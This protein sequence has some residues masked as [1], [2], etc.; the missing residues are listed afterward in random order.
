MDKIV[1]INIDGEAKNVTIIPEHWNNGQSG[2]ENAD[3][4]LVLDAANKQR[5][6]T[7]CFTEDKQDWE[8]NSDLDSEAE[9]EIASYIKRQSPLTAL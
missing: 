5:L 4:Y 2:F 9:Y 6:A 1:S 7:I 3:V 8:I